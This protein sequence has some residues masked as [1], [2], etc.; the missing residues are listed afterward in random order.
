MSLSQRNLGI[1]YTLLSTFLWGGA[2]VVARLADG[3]ISPLTL[4]ASRWLIALLALSLFTLPKLKKEWPVAKTFL[5]NLLLASLAGITL[6]APLSYFAA[7][8]TTATN[9]GLISVISPIFVLSI[10]VFKGEKQ[11]MNT[12]IGCL[13][14]LL[15]SVF[16]VT[17][18]SLSALA[19]MTFV[20]G[21]LIMLGAAF[22]FAIYSICLRSIPKGLSQSSVLTLL[23]FFGLIFMLPFLIWEVN[24]P[25]FVFNLNP[26]VIFSIAFTGL[27]ASLAAWWCYNL[28]LSL[29]GAALA[30]I[31]YYTLPLF[32]AILG[33]LILG[34]AITQTQMISAAL[35]I[36]GIYW[37]TR[38]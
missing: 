16:L 19:N 3:Q 12:W 9:L 25:S 33:F 11:S 10:L 21:D 6:F 22:A 29:A 2:F 27:G 24:S 13:I 26:T 28:G 14:A 38:K 1:V 36:G 15:G 35:I 23:A 8:T 31:I 32:S 5:P 37:S 7:A 30:N 17:G 18:G 34:E 20:E 4:G